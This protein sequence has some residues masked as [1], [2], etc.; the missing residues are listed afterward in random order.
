MVFFHRDYSV[1]TVDLRGQLLFPL[2]LIVLLTDGI[3]AAFREGF[4]WKPHAFFEVELIA[5]L[6]F[7]HLAPGDRD[8]LL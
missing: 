3:I 7:T 2:L 8:E 1:R 5:L 4:P 6:F